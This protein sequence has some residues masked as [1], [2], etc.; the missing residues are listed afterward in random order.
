MAF[1]KKSVARL[2]FI[3]FHG[4]LT[5][6]QCSLY[7]TD[8]VLARLHSEPLSLGFDAGI[9]PGLWL[10]A[11]GLRRQSATGRLG[12]YPDRTFTG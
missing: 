6:R 4:K 2:S 8:C 9:S 12:P 3:R 1:A 5:T 7:A 11:S 10:L